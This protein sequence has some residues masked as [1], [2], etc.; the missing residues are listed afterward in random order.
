MVPHR[1]A[2]WNYGGKLPAS[3]KY[4]NLHSFKEWMIHLCQSILE[5]RRI[6]HLH[7]SAPFPIPLKYYCQTCLN[8]HPCKTTTRLRRPMLSP[9]KQIAVQSLLYKT[10]TCLTQT[11]TIFLTRKWKKTRLKQPLQNFIQRRN[12]KQA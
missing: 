10:T 12:A 1:L 9:P 2:R 5:T 11:P 6:S 3:I 4:Q 7:G 8:D